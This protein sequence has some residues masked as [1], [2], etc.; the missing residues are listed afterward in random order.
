LAFQFKNSTPLQVFILAFILTLQTYSQQRLVID[1]IRI[2]GNKRTR[3]EYLER[4]IKSKPGGPP[5]SV[6]IGNDLRRLGNLSGVMHATACLI[7]E[8]S[9]L[10]LVYS[11]DE[12]YTLLPVGDFGITEDNFLI[13]AGLM[14]SNLA[15]RGIYVYGYYQY[16]SYNTV[17][18]IFRNPYLHGSKWGT[19]FQLKNLPASEITTSGHKLISR[20]FDMSLAA[21][22]E[23]RLENEIL[24]GTS[25][26]F[27]SGKTINTDTPDQPVINY[28]ERY[29][30]TLFIKWEI[31]K[32]CY[33]YFYIDGWRNDLHFGMVF[34]YHKITNPI[35]I[36]FDEFRFYKRLGY[37][38]NG[39]MRLLV[40]ISGEN[41]TV[42]FPFI[43]DSYYNFRGIGYRADRGNMIGLMNLEYRLTLFENRMAGIQAVVFNDSGFLQNTDVSTS[44]ETFNES[45]RSFTGLGIRLIYKKAYNA[46]L[47]IDYGI[48]LASPWEGG[49]VVGW[50]QYF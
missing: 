12:R 49:W 50:G 45:L 22:Y 26:R 2:E 31:R 23:F 30:Q 32:L 13:G 34:P 4:F 47:S 19:E 14:E 21:R 25:Y 16:S 29:A 20:Y 6:T 35:L 15:G 40:G 17:H 3:T 33:T 9:L 48:N 24:L 41:K 5:D 44:E 11:I 39:A 42:F 10:T 8:D 1:S 36:C 38:G 18:L 27:Q 37:K 43:A 46:V 7:H 28:Q